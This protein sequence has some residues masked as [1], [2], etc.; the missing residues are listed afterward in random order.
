MNEEGEGENIVVRDVA[1]A[2]Y[3]GTAYVGTP[4]QP[5]QVVFDTGSAD[6]WVPSPACTHRSGNCGGKSVYDSKSSSTY[7]E[8]KS[9]AK[10]DFGIVYG[11]GPVQGK[12]VI[13]SVK[14]ADD[15]VVEAQ[16]F[17]VADTTDG[18]GQVY[19]KAKFDGIL[20][21]AFPSLS[22]NPNSPTVLDNLVSQGQLKSAMFA[23]YLGDNKDGELTL[24]GY[25]ESLVDG[26]INWVNLLSATYWLSPVDHVKF[27]DIV[28]STRNT[29]GIMDTGTSLLYG[30]QDAV[31]GMAK[32]IGGQFVPQVR[33]FMIDCNTQIPD[34]EFKIGGQPYTIPGEA[35]TIKDSSGRYCFLGISI[36]NFGE[37]NEATQ[38][39]L[40]EELAEDVVEEVN[41]LVGA[42]AES[43]IPSGYDVWLVGDTFLRQI[44]TIFDYGNKRIGY[45][46]LK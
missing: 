25:D 37:E 8:P 23:F 22:Q 13:D 16:T 17:A 2:Q 26:D 5:F 38:A 40:A 31:M 7:K 29:A 18:L 32:Q 19:E 30:P 21:L 33:M 36:M 15:F 6:F 45:A 10:T 11:S 27:G 44:Y 24:G 28:I 39:T 3:W 4:P 14:L 1:N 35:L 43:P 34:L 12:Y 46:K 42:T 20:G 9:P 41:R